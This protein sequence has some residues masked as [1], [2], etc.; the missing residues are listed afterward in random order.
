MTLT[1]TAYDRSPEAVAFLAKVKASQGWCNA[2]YPS[3]LSRATIELT[4]FIPDQ[5][6]LLPQNETY[7]R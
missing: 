2:R 5:P 6:E 4:A 3:K 1:F 7:P